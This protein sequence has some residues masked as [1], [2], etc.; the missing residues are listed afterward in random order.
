MMQGRELPNN[1]AVAI[2]FKSGVVYMHMAYICMNTVNNECK[3]VLVLSGS[4]H[5]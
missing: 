1:A 2:S 3:H 5:K 4:F